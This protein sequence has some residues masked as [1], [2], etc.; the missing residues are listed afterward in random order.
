[1]DG[2]KGYDQS[3]THLEYEA[4]KQAGIP[5]LIF[6][7]D[8]DTP[9]PPKYMANGEERQKILQL[10]DELKQDIGDYD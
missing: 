6:L 3:I 10:R 4:A 8:K 5:R 9:W 7:L 1:M 2:G